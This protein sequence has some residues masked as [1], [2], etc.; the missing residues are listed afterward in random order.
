MKRCLGCMQSYQNELTMCPHCGYVENTS[1]EEAIHMVPGTILQDRFIIGKVVGC[2]GFG[3]TY[4]AWD[5]VLDHKVAIKE[6]LPSEFSTR[7]PGI[8]H[9]TIFEGDKREQFDDGMKKFLDEARRLAKFQNESGIVKIFDCFEEN[10]TAYIVMEYLQGVT[11]THYLEEHGK[12]SEDEAVQMILPILNSLKNVHRE[13]I[14]HRDIAP[15]NIMVTTDGQVKLID[16]GA[17]R[18][19]TTSHSRS[20]TVIIKQGYSPV[21]QYQ[22]RGDQ[23][24]YTDVYAIGAVLYKMITGVTPPDSMERNAYFENSRKDIL[25]P[26]HKLVKGISEN[27]EN[28]ILNSMNIRIEDRSPDMDSLIKELTTDE[29]VAR[30]NGKIKKKDIFQWPLWLKITIPMAMMGVIALF[31]LLIT[32]VIGFDFKKPREIVVP[33]GMT[34]VPRIV[35]MDEDSAKSLLADKKLNFIVTGAEYDSLIDEGCVLTQAMEVGSIVP[36]NSNLEVVISAGAECF[37]VPYLVGLDKDKAVELLEDNFFVYEI[38]EDYSSVI[39]TDCVISQSIVGGTELE[40]GSAVNIVIS[41][42]R[43]PEVSYDFRGTVMPN[44]SGK[45]FEEVITICEGYGI[46]LR[47]SDYEHSNQV[48]TSCVITQSVDAGEE[49]SVDMVVELVLSKGERIY[50]VPL[51][52]YLSKEKATEK[53]ADKGFSCTVHYEYSE[54]VAEGYVISQSVPSGE[55]VDPSTVIVLTVSKGMPKF[56]MIDVCGMTEG[57]AITALQELGLVVTVSYGYNI[58]IEVGTVISQSKTKY[59]KVY[60][61]CEVEI[62]VCSEE[63]LIEVPDC[64]GKY[65]NEYL[66]EE[67]K[68]LGFNVELNVIEE[69]WHENFDYTIINQTPKAGSMQKPGTTII[70]TYKDSVP[71]TEDTTQ[72]TTQEWWEEETTQEWW[73]EVTQEQIPT[74]NEIEFVIPEGCIYYKHS[75]GENYVAGEVLTQYAGLGDELRTKDY[76]YVNEGEGWSV[77]TID[78]SKTEYEALLST[79]AGEPVTDLYRTFYDCVNLVNAPQMP[80]NVTNMHSTFA[81]CASLETAPQIPNGVIS[82]QNA[83]YGCTSLKV[84]PEIPYGVENMQFTFQKCTSL[85]ITPLIPESVTNMGSTFSNCEALITVSNIPSKVT[86]LTYTF[87]NCENLVTVPSIPEGV[88][89]LTSTFCW[90]FSLV[91]APEIP[92]SVVNMSSTFDW[93]RNLLEAPVIP[94]GVKNMEKTFW[95]CYSIVEA[96]K[97]P[98]SV[99]N[100]SSTFAHCQNLKTASQIPNGVESLSSTFEN[101]YSLVNVPEIPNSVTSLFYTFSGCEKLQTAPIISTN[102]TDMRGVF[103]KCTNLTSSVIIN[104]NPLEYENCFHGVDF[105]AQN[106]T[107]SG[108][109]TMLDELRAT[110]KN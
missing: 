107:L 18:Y 97:L 45:T 110:G 48:P 5:K 13:G 55:I 77:T 99:E 75:T 8:S 50:K 38:T 43:N 69:V 65:P 90:C 10:R 63:T 108:T 39:E 82:L 68:E 1:P 96:P 4:I 105:T 27:K 74:E 98:N 89:D 3:V 23:G 17:A 56:D 80:E 46:L 100:L 36:V 54:T 19:A 2:G 34:R 84:A 25:E 78:K 91:E 26:I 76:V 44:L 88:T 58:E 51:V 49:I 57:E 32:G 95:G 11:L 66:F 81:G 22:S 12:I 47:V 67:L 33:D 70:I 62:V 21:E 102:V 41:K 29:P 94:E 9:L 92:S 79:I 30:I 73:E 24:A 103:E 37:D 87:F 83:F 31:V 14:I 52:T 42:G 60:K 72:E 104:A 20:L 6:Y 101:C 64:V 40:K 86:N 53:L 109:S 61:G 93:C 28:A 15:D 85:E 7:M 35:S 16:F 59:E 71:I 106:L